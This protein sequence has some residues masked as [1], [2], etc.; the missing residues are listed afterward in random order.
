LGVDLAGVRQVHHFE[1][2]GKAYESGDQPRRSGERDEKS[3]ELSADQTGLKPSRVGGRRGEISWK[4]P[5]PL[6]VF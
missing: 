5:T 3:D 1:T 2:V 4:G 6:S